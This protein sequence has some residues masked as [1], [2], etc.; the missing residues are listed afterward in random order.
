MDMMSDGMPQPPKV[1]WWLKLLI[2]IAGVD[3]ETLRKCSP[4]D[5]DNVRAVGEIMICTWLYQSGLFVV[6]LHRIFASP[7]QIRPEFVLVSMFIATFIMFIDSY[8]VMRSGW[9]LEGLKALGHAGL[10]IA[11]GALARIKAGIF[12]SIRICLSIGLAQLTAIFVSLL[13][14]GADID[15]RIH[16]SYLRAN[17]HLVGPAT[18]LVDAAIQRATDAATAQT[19]QV[20]DLAAQVAAVRQNEID[21]LSSD[22]QIREA[23]EEVSQLV[24]DKAKAEE[25]VRNAETFAANE[26]G[27]IKGNQGNSGLAGYGL[28]YRAAM[29]QLK[30]ARLHAQNIDKQLDAARARL[31]DLRRK[32]P[33]ASDTTVQQTQNQLSSFQESLNAENDKLSKLKDELAKLIEGRENAIRKSIEHAP[34]HVGLDDGFLT[35]IA[36][37]ERIAQEDRKIAAIILLIDLVSFGFEL[38]AVL[39]K[40][41]SYV[42]TTYSALLASGGYMRVVEI[43]EDMTRRLKDLDD[44]GPT[45]PEDQ[46]PDKP[47]DGAPGGSA[48]AMSELPAK[49]KRG[50]PRKYPLPAPITGANGQGN[51]EAA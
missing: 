23:R 50:R 6:I 19:K 48:A 46:A 42:P 33:V 15:A 40:V 38:A 30:N 3:E 44:K 51:S 34:D 17:G 39:A 7:G 32:A 24:A 31:A 4:H 47:L 16:A 18:A 35:Q 12:L 22:P 41:T 9:H 28:R 27:G 45:Q 29:E 43:V 49:R 2:K 10:E 36:V 11:G 21:P 5:W 14:F 37:L 25:A 20:N 1:G 8:M 26:Y 13:I